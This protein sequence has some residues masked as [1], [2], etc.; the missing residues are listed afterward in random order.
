M[1]AALVINLDP[2]QRGY[3]LGF[4]VELREL[5]VSV[6]KPSALAAALAA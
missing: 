3:V 2:R 4:P 1:R 6:N 5:L